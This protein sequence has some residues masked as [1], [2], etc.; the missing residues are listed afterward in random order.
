MNTS[1]FSNFV[2][3]AAFYHFHWFLK[4]S[5][6]LCLVT[7]NNY[8]YYCIILSNLRKYLISLFLLAAVFAVNGADIF[9]HHDHYTDGTDESKCAECILNNSLNQTVISPQDYVTAEFTVEFI[10]HDNPAP[11]VNLL[12]QF[13]LNNKAPP[14][15]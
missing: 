9:H 4:N 6:K 2:H 1:Q 15:A 7:I 10:L 8:Y 14:S 12:L 11:L 13:N 3:L 5:F